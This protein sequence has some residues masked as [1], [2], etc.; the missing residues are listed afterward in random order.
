MKYKE[1]LQ[2][3]I[4]KKCKRNKKKANKNQFNNILIQL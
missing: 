3:K 4:Y 1:L 2:S